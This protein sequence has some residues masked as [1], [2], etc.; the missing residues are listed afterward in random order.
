MGAGFPI[1]RREGPTEGREHTGRRASG[2]AVARR[3]PAAARMLGCE[4]VGP[5]TNISHISITPPDASGRGETEDRDSRRK[6]M[7][8]TGAGC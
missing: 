6:K 4:S 7:A 2:I 8:T 3:G 1:A 5:D